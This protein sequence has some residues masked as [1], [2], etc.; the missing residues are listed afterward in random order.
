M[1]E[2]KNISKTYQT[3]GQEVKALDNL[4]LQIRDGDFLAVI[5]HSGC[6]KTTMLNIMAGYDGFDRGTYLYDGMPVRMPSSGQ[7]PSFLRHQIGMIFQEYHLLPYL[8]VY[9]NIA[10][11]TRYQRSDC[12]KEN[13]ERLLDN[14]DLR[15]CRNKYPHQLSGG[16]KQRVAIARVLV[17]DVR[18]ILADEPT[19]A[20]DGENAAGIMKI[21]GTLN[22]Q[23]MTIILVT[24]DLAIAKRCRRIAVMEKGH[25]VV[26]RDLLSS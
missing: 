13:I 14:L 8:S 11:A 3:S 20:L 25:V 19:G 6:G 2:L 18:V 16:Q 12:G 9:D 7:A 1:I 21:F 22:S 23:G 17:R 4:N 5:G 15:E 10:L 26:Q 24:H